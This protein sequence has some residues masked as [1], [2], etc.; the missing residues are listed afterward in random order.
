MKSQKRSNNTDENQDRLSDLPDCVLFRILSGLDAKKAVQTCILSKRWKNM[1]RYLSVV[2]L[3]SLNFKT[4]KSFTKFVSRFLSLHDKETALHTLKFHREGIMESHLLKRIFKYAVSH[5]VEKLYINCYVE[6]FPLR[7]ISC[8]TLT[9]LNLSANIKMDCQLPIFS[10]SLNLPALSSLC[11]ESF[12][13]RSGGNDGCAEPFSSFNNLNTLII[14][15]FEILDEEYLLISNATLVNLTIKTSAQDYCK[16]ELST[17][18]LCNFDF[19]GNPVHKLNGSNGN[20]SSIKHV[21]IDIPIW[22]NKKKISLLLLNWL[23]K[24]PNIE[25]LTVSAHILQVL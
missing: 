2:S 11:L 20:L 21:S 9:S 18:S 10:N 17:P 8:H 19:S 7:Y 23:A 14:Q 6:H 12:A 22:S 4:L 13:F 15:S 3:S 5:N 24:L 25:S 1:W 16:I